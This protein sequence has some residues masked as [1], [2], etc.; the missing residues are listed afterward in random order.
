MISKYASII[1]TTMGEKKNVK[2]YTLFFTLTTLCL[3]IDRD[4]IW[5]RLGKKHHLRHTIYIDHVTTQNL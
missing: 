4:H 1:Y 2:E 3:I 5:G